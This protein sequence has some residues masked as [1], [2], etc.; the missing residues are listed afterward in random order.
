MT[1]GNLKGKEFISS[2]RESNA[3]TQSENLEAGTKAEDTEEC[4]IVVPS[5][6]SVELPFFH[7]P[8]L[9]A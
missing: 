3:E 8:G 7:S 4:C 6:T 5:L 1:N 9:P 2:Y